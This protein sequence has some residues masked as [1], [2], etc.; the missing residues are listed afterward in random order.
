MALKPQRASEYGVFETEQARAACLHLATILGDLASDVTVI[1]GLAPGLIVDQHSGAERHVGTADLD[2]ALGIAVFDERRYAEIAARLRRHGFEPDR[3]EKGGTT[4]QRWRRAG[5]KITIDFLIAAQHAGV[6]P[7]SV[8]WLEDDFAAIG[9]DG[10]DLAF[11]DRVSV[12]LDGLTLDGA[13]ARRE[14][15]VSGPG[16]FTVLKAR[17]FHLRGERTDA[18][19]L[20]YLLVNWPQGIVDIAARM[21]R[22]QAEDTFKVIAEAVAN[23]GADFATPDHNGP[24]SYARFLD[25]PSDAERVALQAQAYAYVADLLGHFDRTATV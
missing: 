5:V 7:G 23:L 25:A 8:K 6:A 13:L 2:V 12:D 19:D 18:Y 22:L 11:H 9:A 20:V 10:A 16:A 17:A 1:G 14:V 24:G 4:P 21:V 15:W 3:N